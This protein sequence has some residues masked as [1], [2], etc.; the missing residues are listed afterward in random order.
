MCTGLPLQK[1][2]QVKRTERG[3]THKKDVRTIDV[4]PFPRSLS[5]V[6]KSWALSYKICHVLLSQPKK[7]LYAFA[8]LTVTIKLR[9]ILC[10]LGE[11]RADIAHFWLAQVGRNQ[12]VN[13]NFTKPRREIADTSN[14]DH[15]LSEMA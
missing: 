2:F 14:F 11:F 10:K 3:A 4:H 15:E 1:S 7:C 12:F 13:T 6:I 8:I 5:E 9:T